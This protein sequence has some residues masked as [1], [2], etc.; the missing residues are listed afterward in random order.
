MS[1]HLKNEL[2]SLKNMLIELASMV[3]YSLKTSVHS[4]SEHDPV[5][6]NNVI[7]MDKNIDELEVN[8]E[9]ECLKI[10][11]LYQPVAID[12]RSVIS[13]LKMNNDLER[14]GDLA[15]NISERSIYLW[16]SGNKLEVFDFLDMTDKVGNML[17]NA[18][19]SAINFDINMAKKV[20]LDDDEVDIMNRKTH[21]KVFKSIKNDPKNAESFIHSLSISRYLERAADYATNIA[22]DVIYMIEGSI[23]RHSSSDACIIE[24]KSMS[25]SSK[26]KK[27]DE[28]K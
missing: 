16:L 15:V 3:E 9:E 23:V 18:I 10:L 21:D 11:A 8:I 6:A 12:L 26:Q 17:H 20:L 19:E 27:H 7:L 25:I 2:E 24:A 13:F 22:E 28:K 4:I 14:I 5:L 1:L